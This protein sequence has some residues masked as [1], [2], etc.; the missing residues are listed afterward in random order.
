MFII[1]TFIGIIEKGKRRS[2]EVVARGNKGDNS[3]RF[4]SCRGD[5]NE[6]I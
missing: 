1:L 5:G 3:V 6:E 2:M 4:Y